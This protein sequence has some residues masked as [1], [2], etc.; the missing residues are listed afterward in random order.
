MAIP[1]ANNHDSAA[2]GGFWLMTLVSPTRRCLRPS[3]ANY[4]DLQLLVECKD[5]MGEE[6]LPVVSGN[7]RSTGDFSAKEIFDVIHMVAKMI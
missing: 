4:P 1:A 6:L 5:E 2:R 7:S 3:L